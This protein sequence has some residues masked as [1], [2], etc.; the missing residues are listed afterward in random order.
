MAQSPT[1]ANILS[2][3]LSLSLFFAVC[4]C[5]GKSILAWI[6]GQCVKGSS[7]VAEQRT[8]TVSVYRDRE[9]D[10]NLEESAWWVSVICSCFAVIEPSLCLVH[11]CRSSFPSFKGFLWEEHLQALE[12][13]ESFLVFNL[14][15][16]FNTKQLVHTIAK[17]LGKATSRQGKK[18][19]AGSKKW[20][21][22]L[23]LFFAQH[24]PAMYQICLCL[25]GNTEKHF[26]EVAGRMFVCRQFNT[27]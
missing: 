14:I 18:L 4:L 27:G 12:V 25:E 19:N 13:G 8:C 20:N 22:I 3:S 15:Q 6:W 10:D 17:G 26:A 7:L 9:C 5:L 23:F 1:T 2:L 21:I 11:G 16:T 24:P